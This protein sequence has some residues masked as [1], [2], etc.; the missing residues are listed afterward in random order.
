M[1]SSDYTPPEQVQLTF[2]YVNG[3]SE[4]FLIYNDVEAGT[5]R[6]DLRQEMRRLLDGHWWIL[7]L[8]EETVV[9][10]NANVLK[11]EIKPPLASL[12][13]EGVLDNAE[14]ITALNRGR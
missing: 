14:R 8:P 1:Y 2:H 5:T 9:I 13:G 6:Q 7:K 11:V 4:S 10:N 3:Q 12:Q